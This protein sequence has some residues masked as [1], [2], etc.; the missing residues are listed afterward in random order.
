MER[1]VTPPRRGPHL[2]GVLHLHV[3]KPLGIVHTTLHK[4]EK[5][6]FYLRLGLPSTL[7][8]Q[9]NGASRKR[10][11]KGNLKTLYVFRV[12]GKHFENV[13]ITTIAWFPCPNFPQTQIIWC[14]FRVKTPFSNSSGEVWTENIWGVFRVRA[15]VLEFC[16]SSVDGKHL[17]RFQSKT[18]VLNSS[19]VLWTGPGKKR[20]EKCSWHS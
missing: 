4:F 19:G 20:S 6:A 13:G 17:M 5:A 9:E 3:N 8:R 11:S 15:S 1:L 18:Y 14:V 2:P 10:T 7:I 12:D 16:R